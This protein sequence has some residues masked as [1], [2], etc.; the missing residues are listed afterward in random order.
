MSHPLPDAWLGED[1]LPGDPIPIVQ[2]WLA[3]A[4]EA[5]VQENPH[6]IAL[7]TVDADG[8]PSVRMVLCTQIEDAGNLVFHTNRSSRKGAA[9][10]GDPRAAAVFHWPN[11]QV[12][13][14]GEAMPLPDAESDAYFAG[15]PRESQL[16]AWASEQSAPVASRAALTERMAEEA[17]RFGEGEVPRPPHWGGYRLVART[18]EIWASRPGRIHDR[19]LWTRGAGGAWSSERL[20]P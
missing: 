19:A 10:A 5:G 1:P 12:R 8:A 11:R 3:Q 7:A 15:R 14:E 17:R 13:V 18:V 20:Q 6:A 9:L 16:G 4:F 2:R